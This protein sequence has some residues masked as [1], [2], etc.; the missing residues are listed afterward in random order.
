MKEKLIQINK[1]EPYFFYLFVLLNLL[2]VLSFKYFPT[3]DGP[4]HLYNSKIITELVTDSNSA[5]TQYFSFN[6]HISPNWTGHLILSFFLLFLP[7]FLAEKIIL[8]C[9]LIGFPLSIRYLYK[10]LGITTNYSIY[11]I[12]PFTYSYLFYFGFYNFNIAL[13]LYFIALSSVIRFGN[14]Y[15]AK[16][17]IKLMLISTLICMS[18][19]FIFAILLLTIFFFKLKDIVILFK[20]EK[21][22]R[23][24]LIKHFLVLFF[25][26]LP[27]LIILVKF[28]FTGNSGVNSSVYLSVGDI[29]NSL[30]YIM[31]AKGINYDEYSV[32]TRLLLYIFTFLI[33]YHTLSAIYQKIVNKRN[34]LKNTT[35][36]LLSLLILLLT[37][38]LPDSNASF[39][40]I[41]SRFMLIFFLFLIISIGSQ[42]LPISFQVLLFVVINFVNF[43]I[44]VHNYRSVS[45]GCLLSKEIITASKLIKPY[46]TILPVNTSEKHLYS[47]ISNYL[48]SE[49]PV[50]ILENYEATLDYFPLKWNYRELPEC[51]GTNQNYAFD[52][53]NPH[54]YSYNPCIDYILFVSD[55]SSKKDKSIMQS[56]D[57]DYVLLFADK[58]SVIQ[59]MKNKNAP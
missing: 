11:L 16:R 7:A 36:I 30:K 42:K 41:S 46:S 58:D 52:L 55:K 14:D 50:V 44:L 8:L 45:N 59:L 21:Q 10:T 24:D 28:A 17:A 38:I 2:P 25:S 13:V 18:H 33:L 27:G 39:G 35:W 43:S 5:L 1:A 22:V 40:F 56:I 54:T 15:S 3:V 20:C 6:D 37:F 19:L 31:P 12:F 49:K 34:I 53:M 9:W 23:S 47:H 29:L 57:N 32:V 4:A 51:F 26:I 48:G